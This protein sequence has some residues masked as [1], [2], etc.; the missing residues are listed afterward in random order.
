MAIAPEDVSERH[1][2]APPSDV[3]ESFVAVAEPRIVV[4][5]IVERPLMESVELTVNPFPMLSPP[6]IVDVVPEAETKSDPPI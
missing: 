6:R 5:A 1:P 4:D 3:I 2:V